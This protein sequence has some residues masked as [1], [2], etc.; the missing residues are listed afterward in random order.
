MKFGLRYCNTG[1]YAEDTALAT[2]LVQ[3]GEE[4]GFESAWT[5]EHTVVPSATSR[6]TPT[7]R[8]ARWPEGSRTSPCPTP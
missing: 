4:A 5:I 3:A 7:A 2:E 1:A 8:T 6:R